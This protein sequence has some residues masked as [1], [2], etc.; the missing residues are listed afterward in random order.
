M[1]ESEALFKITKVIN[2]ALGFRYKYC[3][4]HFPGE[5]K[6]TFDFIYKGRDFSVNK[7]QVYDN[8]FYLGE[9]CAYENQRKRWGYG[10]YYWN[11]G[12]VY[13]GEWNNGDRVG[14]GIYIGANGYVYVGQYLNDAKNGH[15]CEFTLSSGIEVEG[16]FQNDKIKKVSRASS[17]FQT[18]DGHSYDKDS[19]SFTSDKD[20]VIGCL[21]WLVIIFIVF[22][23]CT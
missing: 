18:G 1:T 2:W 16:E 23:C 14:E 17:S 10:T 7:L 19:K 22:K 8:G 15:G 3:C 20:S 21:V 13:M 5:L 9:I 6:E 11:D 4:T 12:S